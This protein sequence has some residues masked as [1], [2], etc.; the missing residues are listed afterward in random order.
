MSTGNLGDAEG[1]DHGARHR[2]MPGTERYRALNRADQ[3]YTVRAS[4]RRAMATAKHS[5]VQHHGV[6]HCVVQHR[7]VQRFDM[8]GFVGL[9]GF[10]RV[11]NVLAPL[12]AHPSLATLVLPDR[13]DRAQPS[14]ALRAGEKRVRALRTSARGDGL[15][16]E[17]LGSRRTTRALVGRGVDGTSSR[18]GRTARIRGGA[19][20]R[21]LR[22]R[23]M[24]Q[25]PA[26]PA[27]HPRRGAGRLALRAGQ[28]ARET[29][30]PPA[31][32]SRAPSH[33]ARLL[34]GPRAHGLAAPEQCGAGLLPSR[35]RSDQLPGREPRSPLP[36]LPPRTRPGGQHAT[37]KGR[38][39]CAR[40]GGDRANRDAGVV[41]TAYGSTA[42]DRGSKRRD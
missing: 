38:D 3:R 25:T 39:G 20:D 15:A 19:L 5:V 34:D 27:R 36:A 32:R 10:A 4:G 24:F 40:G 1:G 18:R 7:V 31:E 35:S 28:G 21:A 8:E 22:T 16:P 42:T 26:G 14:R 29:P 9:K 6:Q 33:A 41:V 30:S 17:P 11:R 2:V 37:A 12:H 23:S 13:L